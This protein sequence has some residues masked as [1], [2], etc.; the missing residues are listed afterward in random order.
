MLRRGRRVHV[1]GT[2]TSEP[3]ACEGCRIVAAAI[4][5][6]QAKDGLRVA[7]LHVQNLPHRVIPLQLRHLVNGVRVVAVVPRPAFGL[8]VS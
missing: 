1:V 8:S 6:V 5:V 4:P 2:R 3:S 7:L